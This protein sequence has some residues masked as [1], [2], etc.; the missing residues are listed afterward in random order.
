ML[1][2]AASGDRSNSFR[3]TSQ[4]ESLEWV[5]ILSKTVKAAKKRYD[6]ENAFVLRFALHSRYVYKSYYSTLT[7]V[8]SI[9]RTGVA[10]RHVY[11]GR[12]PNI[13]QLEHVASFSSDFQSSLHVRLASAVCVRY[14]C[15]HY[16]NLF[17]DGCRHFW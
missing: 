2:E 6:L 13:P 15:H 5:Q 9:F 8:L 16:G 10:V 12:L 1:E 3:T 14:S 4:K 11:L 17:C 7:K